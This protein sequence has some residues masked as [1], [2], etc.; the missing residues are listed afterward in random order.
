M[1]LETGQPMSDWQNGTPQ[2]MQQ[3]L[4][5]ALSQTSRNLLPILDTLARRTVGFALALV[6]HETTSFVELVE[7]LL[8]LR[9]VNYGVFKVR[10]RRLVAPSRYRRARKRNSQRFFGNEDV[11]EGTRSMTLW[12]NFSSFALTFC[13]S[14]TRL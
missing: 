9:I 4:E 2:S 11:R 5:L 3:A 13:S 14:R 1:T 6:L 12:R 7:A 8:G 10:H